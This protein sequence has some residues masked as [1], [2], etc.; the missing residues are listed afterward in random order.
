MITGLKH[1]S[2][3]DRLRELELFSLEKRRL[4]G[5]LG[6]AFQYL[7]WANRRPG[8]GLFT[9]TCSSGARRNGFNLRIILIRYEE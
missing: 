5:E 1:R 6:A 4:W 2:Y 3:D 8:K 9:G 7:K